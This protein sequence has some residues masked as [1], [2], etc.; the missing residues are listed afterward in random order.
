MN[1]NSATSSPSGLPYVWLTADVH[2]QIQ[3]SLMGWSFTMLCN[4]PGLPCNQQQ[5]RPDGELVS[6]PHHTLS[7]APQNSLATRLSVGRMQW[8]GREDTKKGVYNMDTQISLLATNRS[9]YPSNVVAQRNSKCVWDTLYD[10]RPIVYTVWVLSNHTVKKVNKKNKK[11]IQ[12][13]ALC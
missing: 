4:Q 2:V 1:G 5:G 7:T 12:R 11:S 9:M 13:K 10:P 8:P 6:V 3:Y